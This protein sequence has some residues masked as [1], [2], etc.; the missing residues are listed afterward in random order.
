MESDFAESFESK[1]TTIDR[2][3]ISLIGLN[4]ILKVILNQSRKYIWGI[5]STLQFVAYLH[6]VNVRLGAHARSFLEKLEIVALG[7]IIP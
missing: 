4:L 3:T 2:V 6:F 1:V 7:E 5:V